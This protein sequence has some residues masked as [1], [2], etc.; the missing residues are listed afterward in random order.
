MKDHGEAMDPALRAVVEAARG[1]ASKA[2]RMIPDVSEEDASELR[3]LLADLQTAI[4][5]RS[6]ERIQKVS[7]E[8][9]DIV[10]YLEDA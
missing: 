5:H 2:G 9:E 1:L 3:A 8:I 7:R 4:D 6:T 10:F